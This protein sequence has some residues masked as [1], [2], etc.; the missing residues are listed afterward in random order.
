MVSQVAVELGI[1][2]SSSLV[3]M[4][5][6]GGELSE[7][8][9]CIPHQC[10]GHEGQGGILLSVGDGEALFPQ[11]ERCGVIPSHCIKSPLPVQDLRD[12]ER[13][14]YLQTQLL[15]AG[16]GLFHFGGSIPLRG[17]QR[18]AE[19]QLEGQF[20]ASAGNSVWY[21]PKQ[22]ESRSKMGNCVCVR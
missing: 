9:Q 1:V 3:M 17:H 6:R 19:T 16:V 21:G 22:G 4:R 20:L 10:M 15:R 13:L 7:P 11:G 18:R 14:P 8:E 5:L 2:E 12:L